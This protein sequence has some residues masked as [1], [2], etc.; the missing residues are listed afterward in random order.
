M[1]PDDFDWKTSSY[2]ADTNGRCVEVGWHIS[3]Y[4]A[5]TNGRCVE[6]GPV[7]DG[8][9]TYALRDSKYRKLGH[10]TVPR[11]EWATFLHSVKS[12]EL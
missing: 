5:N 2:S 12:G 7:L 8:A 1:R 11:P 9:I 6:A 4:S 3:S 10:L